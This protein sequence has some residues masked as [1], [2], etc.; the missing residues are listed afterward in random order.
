MTRKDV[1]GI[2]QYGGPAA[3]WGALQAVAKAL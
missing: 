2:G 1:P 3:G